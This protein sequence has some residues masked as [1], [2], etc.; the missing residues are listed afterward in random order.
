[1]SNVHPSLATSASATAALFSFFQL[2]I[3]VEFYNCLKFKIQICLKLN[4]LPNYIIFKHSKPDPYSLTQ[5]LELN[6]QR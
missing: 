2:L 6:E 3:K 4:S 1:M 5:V